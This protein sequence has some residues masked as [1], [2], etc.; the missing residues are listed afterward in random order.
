MA[1][2]P[3]YCTS[4]ELKAFIRKATAADDTQIGLAIS[5]ASRA[6]DKKTNRQFGLTGSAVARVY[7]WH[8]EAL[9]GRAALPIDD[10]QTTTGLAVGLDLAADGA[11]S[12]AIVSG[13]DF[14]LWPWNAAANGKPWTHLVVR[15]SAAAALPCGTRGIQV[16][17][18]WGWSAVPDTVK[19]ACMIQAGRFYLR[20]DSLYGIAGSPDTGGELRL[21]SKLD[22]D[23]ALMLSSVTRTWGAV[24]A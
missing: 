6:I 16:T 3:N 4:A 24:S 7:T 14:D 10:L 19:Q 12:Q 18:N 13:T 9:E 21:L 5:A 8:G 1:W 23:V 11:F 22:P 2:A 20:R 15:P 17:A